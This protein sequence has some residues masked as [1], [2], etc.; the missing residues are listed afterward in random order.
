MGWV[1]RLGTFGAV[2]PTRLEVSVSNCVV[3][4]L[5]ALRVAWLVTHET[6]KSNRR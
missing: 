1:L 3:W 6:R 5:E 2:S 4:G